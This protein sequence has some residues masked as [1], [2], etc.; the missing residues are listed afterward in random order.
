MLL[1][2]DAVIRQNSTLERAW[3][4]YKRLMPSLLANP[5]EYGSTP[6]AVTRM[7]RLVVGLDTAVMKGASFQV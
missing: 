1:T 3:D 5:A 4:K 7:A 2:M 6:D